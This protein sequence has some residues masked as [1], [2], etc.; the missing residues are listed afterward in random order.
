[1]RFDLDCGCSFVT[2]ATL[3]VTVHPSDGSDGSTATSNVQKGSKGAKGWQSNSIQCAS[4]KNSKYLAELDLVR[5]TV[6]ECYLSNL[7]CTSSQ[8][9]TT[10]TENLNIAEASCKGYKI[11]QDLLISESLI[12]WCYP[13]GQAWLKIIMSHKH[14]C[15]QK[16]LAAQTLWAWSL[17]SDI[18]YPPPYTTMSLCCPALNI[19]QSWI[20]GAQLGTSTSKMSGRYWGGDSSEN[21]DLKMGEL[22]CD[23]LVCVCVSWFLLPK[24]S[25]NNQGQNLSRIVNTP[26][27]RQLEFS[28]LAPRYKAIACWK[29]SSHVAISKHSHFAAP[30]RSSRICKRPWHSSAGGP[31][32][33]VTCYQVR[34]KVDASRLS[35][36]PVCNKDSMAMPVD[37]CGT[38]PQQSLNSLVV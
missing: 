24:N 36:P 19:I 6:D 13:T 37:D 31:S 4:P 12:D 20:D 9:Q 29:N 30:P 34:L 2:R 38:S 5:L 7:H 23:L 1:M 17:S 35:G 26:H 14:D 28:R 10:A 15:S 33:A 27:V 3:S 32:K 11:L 22:L 25:P 18:R 21:S 8:C 16:L